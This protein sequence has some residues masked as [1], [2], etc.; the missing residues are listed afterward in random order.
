[1]MTVKDAKVAIMEVI[2]DESM[3]LP[4]L[5][6]AIVHKTLGHDRLTE[7]SLMM[8]EGLDHTVRDAAWNLV[9]G[10]VLR[11]AGVLRNGVER[12]V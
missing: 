5:T 9:S 1:M 10:G 8:C 11:W 12:N 4:A 6:V 2:G 7:E 3:S